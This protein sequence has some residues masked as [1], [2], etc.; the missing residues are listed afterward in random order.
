MSPEVASKCS[1]SQFVRRRQLKVNVWR[2]KRA[3]DMS[4]LKRGINGQPYSRR[5]SHGVVLEENVVYNDGCAKEAVHF[6]T[7]Q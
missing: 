7:C 1:I 4:W 2:T 5:Q 3:D 6:I